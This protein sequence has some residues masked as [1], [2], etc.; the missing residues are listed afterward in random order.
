MSGAALPPSLCAF[1]VLQIPGRRGDLAAAD[2]LV[3]DVPADLLP[4]VAADRDEFDLLHAS[5]VGRVESGGDA[6]KA[7]LLL[8]QIF[9]RVLELLHRL[10]PVAH[11]YMVPHACGRPDT[12]RRRT[13]SA[14]LDMPP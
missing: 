8:A 6:T 3:F 5:L 11:A 9:D 12:T 10:V 2:L 4:V 14:D 1:E 7:L 13:G